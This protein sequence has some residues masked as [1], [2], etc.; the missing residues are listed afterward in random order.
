MSE[1]RFKHVVLLEHIHVNSVAYQSASGSL[2]REGRHMLRGLMADLSNV[3]DCEL[4]VALCPQAAADLQ[5]EA[6]VIN[7]PE[8]AAGCDDLADLLLSQ[9]SEPVA[10]ILIAPE[11]GMALPKLV[12]CLR[13]R[14][15]AVLAP[16]T[17][18]VEA[19][20]DKWQT[21][22]LL[23][24]S[25]LPTIATERLETISRL[26]LAEDEK[27]IIKPRDGAGCEGVFTTTPREIARRQVPGA[28]SSPGRI[29]QPL[30]EGQ[31]LSVGLIGQGQ[32]HS[33]LFLPVAEQNIQWAGGRPRYRGGRVPARL[34]ASLKSDIT[35]LC[36]RIAWTLQLED[37]YVGVDLILP[38]AASSVIITE[39]NPRLCSS[40]LGYRLAT[41][42]NLATWVLQRR[43]GASVRW[44]DDTIEFDVEKS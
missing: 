4:R 23:Q 35:D 24:R 1:V 10:V 32:G 6:A 19:C 25:G 38:S 15:I 26:G 12:R 13:R 8:T 17:E 20:S 22:E 28:G 40:Y 29:V 5:P 9:T 30:I 41:P 31:S 39:I 37:G 36:H 21:H 11:I 16:R 14:G 34:S 7:V 42:D 43:I 2:R 44:A 27:C 18:V 3:P 33:P